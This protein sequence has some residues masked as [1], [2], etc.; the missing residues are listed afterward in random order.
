MTESIHWEAFA[1]TRIAPRNPSLLKHAELVRLVKQVQ[2]HHPAALTVRR[3][4]ESVEG[5]AIH[6]IGL[7]DGPKKILLWTQMHGDEPTHT[8]VLLDLLNYFQ[9]DDGNRIVEEIRA[10]CTIQMIL[11]LNPDG[12]ERDIRQNAQEIDI[13][14][15]AR[16]LQSPDA[17]ILK[18]AVEAFQP[19]FAFNLHNQDPRNFVET[20]GE[21]A[22]V[23]LMVPPLDP[24]GT[25]T[26][27]ILIAKKVAVC[28]YQAVVGYCRDRIG[29]YDAQYMPGAFG[30][31]VQQHGAATVLVEAGGWPPNCSSSL[32]QIHF[33]GLLLTLAAIATDAYQNADP[34]YYDF[35]P[36]TVQ[37]DSNHPIH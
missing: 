4:G 1:P 31:V 11:M 32:T 30:E 17:R 24:D 25:V 33:V 14:R 8:A 15:D 16:E 12:A 19:D 28:F 18:T 13:N 7:G 2:A 20:T 5:R 21:P 27:Q 3:L 6:R 26:E 34:G 23:S 22:A 10:G 9:C 37:A 29:R 36:M 35:L